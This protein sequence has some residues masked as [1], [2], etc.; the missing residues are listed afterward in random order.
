MLSSAVLRERHRVLH[1]VGDVGPCVK[2]AC[3]IREEVAN[4]QVRVAIAVDVGER[5]CVRVPA[6]A[7]GNHFAS[8]VA[9]G[10]RAQRCGRV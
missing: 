7:A 1:L 2:D 8:R 5:R 10:V 3:S 4:D 6:G 9:I